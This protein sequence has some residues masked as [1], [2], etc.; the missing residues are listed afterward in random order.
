MSASVFSI[1]HPTWVRPGTRVQ[2]LQCHSVRASAKTL[3]TLR[4]IISPLAF[5]LKCH[6]LIPVNSH[7]HP[8][9]PAGLTCL[10]LGPGRNHL[11]FALYLTKAA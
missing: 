9:V 1:T 8:A 4:P 2:L 6:L 11:V 5:L 3:L 10:L 7:F